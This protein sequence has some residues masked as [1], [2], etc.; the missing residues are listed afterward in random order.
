M[1]FNTT[2]NSQESRGKVEPPRA[3]AHFDHDSR[4]PSVLTQVGPGG[5][6]TRNLGVKVKV[7]VAGAAA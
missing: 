4:Q 5:K 7:F 6:C 3:A 2:R 1:K